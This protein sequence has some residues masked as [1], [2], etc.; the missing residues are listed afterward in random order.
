MIG[1]RT[2]REEHGGDG[3]GNDGRPHQSSEQT[4][5][6]AGAPGPDPP[7]ERIEVRERLLVAALART[8][9]CRLRRLVAAAFGQQHAEVA[10]R[11]GVPPLVGAPVGG[12]RAGPITALFEQEAKVEPGNGAPR[13][14]RA[15]IGPLGFVQASLGLEHHAELAPGVAGAIIVRRRRNRPIEFARRVH[16]RSS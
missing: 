12:L 11:R 16:G 6:G 4:A 13:V 7:R 10:C 1:A 3:G 14:A 2:V 15:S 5:A 8:A 9:E